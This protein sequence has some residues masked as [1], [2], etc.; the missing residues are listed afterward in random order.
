M[1]RIGFVG[2]PSSGKTTAANYLAS[3]LTGYRIALIPEFA[4]DYMRAKGGRISTAQ[5]Q[6]G[7][8]TIQSELEIRALM[9]IPQI[10]ITDTPL[11]VTEAYTRFYYPDADFSKNEQLSLTH[12]YDIIFYCKGDTWKEDGI[13]F[14]NPEA[15]Q[16]LEKM[17]NTMV[18]RYHRNEIIILPIDKQERKEYLLKW[19]SAQRLFFRQ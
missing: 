1:L 7:T 15:L 19:L 5:E 3:N 12:K 17:L 9:T 13:R 8:S 4:R 2:L 11:F 16:G 14:Q 18:K 10:M 6:I